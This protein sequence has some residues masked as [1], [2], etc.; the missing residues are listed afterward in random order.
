[1]SGLINGVP[2][3]EWGTWCAHGKR[4]VEP[5]LTVPELAPGYP[6]GRIVTPWPC[7]AGGCTQEAF[8]REMEEID[9]ECEMERWAEY[10][11][12]VGG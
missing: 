9:R 8:E 11:A 5:D 12:L 6:K 3:D 1:M 10:R 7:S 2:A 4:I